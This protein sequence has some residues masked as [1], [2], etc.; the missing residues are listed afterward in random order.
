VVH[1]AHPC[2]EPKWQLDRFS[3]FCWTRS[4][5]R[6]TERQTDRQT[7]LLCYPCLNALCVPNWCKKAL[8][9]YSAF[10]PFLYSVRCGVIMRSYVGYVLCANFVKIWPT[11][12][13]LSRALFTAQKKTKF[14]LALSLLLLRG[15]RPVSARASGKQCTQSA[16]NFIQITFGGVIAKRVNTVQTRHK[17]FPILGKAI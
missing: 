16:P 17:V 2:P 12:S 3:R 8:Y 13:R 10:L 6:L 9:K 4:C 1:L 5:D 14:W 15:S 11:G 7:T